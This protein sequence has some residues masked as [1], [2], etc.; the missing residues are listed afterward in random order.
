MNYSVEWEPNA[1]DQLAA[2]WVAHAPHR[3]DVTAAS[4]R[5]EKELA[6]DPRRCGRP[7]TEGLFAIH[8]SPLRVI[9][10]IADAERVVNI[11]A[12]RWLP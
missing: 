8:V 12:V 9:R 2:I 6:A 1:E 7:V 3:R 4:A 5:I 10:E 11:V